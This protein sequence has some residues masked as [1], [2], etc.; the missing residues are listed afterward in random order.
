[1]LLCP[2]SAYRDVGCGKKGIKGETA[3]LAS[4]KYSKW[5]CRRKD[6]SFWAS[7]ANGINGINGINGQRPRQRQKPVKYR[8]I[9]KVHRS[10]QALAA[11][12][13]FNPTRRTLAALQVPCVL[14]ALSPLQVLH[15]Q[16]GGRVNP[17][18]GCDKKRH[19]LSRKVVNLKENTSTS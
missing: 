4:V 9:M 12:Q 8:S 10:A 3:L 18:V 19:S 14:Q 13:G 15:S 17:N 7:T 6:G 16:S 11:N 5:I 1:M 2:R